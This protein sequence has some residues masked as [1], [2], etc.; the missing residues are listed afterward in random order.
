MDKEETYNSLMNSDLEPSADQCMM[1]NFPDV[2]HL[3]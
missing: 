3:I 2:I 1:N